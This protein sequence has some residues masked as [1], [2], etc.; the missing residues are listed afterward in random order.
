[1]KKPCTESMLLVNAD[2]HKDF[3][4]V[5]KHIQ[6]LEE[7]FSDEIKQTFGIHTRALTANEA[8]YLVGEPL[9]RSEIDALRQK[10]REIAVYY[11]KV[12][13]EHFGMEE[14]QGT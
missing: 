14:V 11:Q 9:T 3:Q 13:A 5:K 2:G 6:L 8:S 7:R 1:M 4:P 12:M 10:K